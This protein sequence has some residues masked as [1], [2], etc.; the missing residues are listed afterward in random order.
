MGG[1]AGDSGKT[2]WRKQHLRPKREAGV[3]QRT[4]EG[5]G[6]AAEEQ[7]VCGPMWEDVTTGNVG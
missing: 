5:P 7:R 3:G 6:G 4:G 2:P 1:L